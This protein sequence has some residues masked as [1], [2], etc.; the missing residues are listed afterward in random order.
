MDQPGSGQVE[1][2]S[3][4]RKVAVI[5][6]TRPEAIK[7]APVVHAL[8]AMPDEFAGVLVSTAQHRDMIREALAAFALQPDEDLDLMRAGDE[9]WRFPARASLALGEWLATN[10][11]DVV[12]VQGDTATTAAAATSA[13]YHRIP[14][15]HVEAGLRSG[16]LSSP[17]PEEFNRRVTSIATAFH[18]APTP[19][20]QANLL[21][22]GVPAANVYVTG[23]TVVDALQMTRRVDTFG[24]PALQG[25][26]WARRIVLVTV[27]RRES[28]GA[29]LRGICDALRRI[30]ASQQDVEI[31]LPV[32]PNPNVRE[33]VHGMLRDAPRI[34]LCAPLAYTETLEV[35]RRSWLVLSDSGGLQEEAPSFRKPILVLRDVTERPEVVESGFGALVGTDP[36]VIVAGVERLARDPSAYQAMTSG[37]NPF[38]DGRASERIAAVLARRVARP[39]PGRTQ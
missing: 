10:R 38:G 28:H 14:V 7:L 6:G 18:F 35:V 34:R 5:L 2:A 8:R 25:V 37:E 20:A 32:H 24:D 30:A 39:V 21:A 31:I 12:V 26:D 33:V 22:E 23:N 19:L 16:D 29:P 1:A 4:P 27:H 15:A 36:A 13:F 11:P 3:G 9:T 17:F